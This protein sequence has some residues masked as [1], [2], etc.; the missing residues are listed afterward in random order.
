[1][2]LLVLTLNKDAMPM[3]K[4]LIRPLELAATELLISMK[5]QV[6]AALCSSI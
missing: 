1:M 2:Y 5:L 3:A 4:P 6:N